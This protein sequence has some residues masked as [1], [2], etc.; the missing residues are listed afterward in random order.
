MRVKEKINRIVKVLDPA[1]RVPF[2]IA[3]DWFLSKYDFSNFYSCC[4]SLPGTI[5][6]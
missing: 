3:I 5:T 1:M 4:K 2:V 6:Y